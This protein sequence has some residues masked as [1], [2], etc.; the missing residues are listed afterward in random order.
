M[1][2]II[3]II[4]KHIWKNKYFNNDMSI[5]KHIILCTA[6]IWACTYSNSK[7]INCCIWLTVFFVF[8]ISISFPEGHT[9]FPKK[10]P[11]RNDQPVMKEHADSSKLFSY[12]SDIP[13][14]LNEITD[15]LIREFI[16]PWFERI[17][18]REDSKFKHAVKTTIL[19]IIKALHISVC[20]DDVATKVSLK[21]IS[22]IT[23]HITVFNTMDI[24]SSY[25][26]NKKASLKYAIT[27][28]KIL[29]IHQ[30]ITLKSDSLDKDIENHTKNI[31]EK[32]LF[33]VLGEEE[34]SSPFVSVLSKEI[35]SMAVFCPLLTKYC[36]PYSWNMSLISIC[37]KILEERSQ[38]QEVRKILTKQLHT[39]QLIDHENITNLKS[40]AMEFNINS[41]T[42]DEDFEIFLKRLSEL[43]SLSDLRSIKLTMMMESLKLSST[44]EKHPSKKINLLKKRIA[45]SLNLVNSKLKY[46]DAK[47]KNI[48][49]DK[50]EMDFLDDKEILLKLE[51]FISRVNLDAILSDNFCMLYFKRYLT[52]KKDT[53]SLLY[54]AFW[55][56]I[57]SLKNPLPS[58]VSVGATVTQI[59]L[60]NME[61]IK[62]IFFNDKQIPYMKVLDEKLVLE[63]LQ[64][65]QEET[66]K[67]DT[68]RDV[69]KIFLELQHKSIL[70]LNIQFLKFKKSGIFI[71]MISALEFSSTNVY[72]GYISNRPTKNSSDTVLGRHNLEKQP[73]EPMEV[74]LNPIISEELEKIANKE[75]SYDST[76]QK[77][78]IADIDVA[79]LM[80]NNSHISHY[81]ILDVKPPKMENHTKNE[82]FLEDDMKCGNPL[83][84]TQGSTLLQAIKCNEDAN[85]SDSDLSTLN[86]D[87]EQLTRELNLLKHLIL[88]AELTNSKKQL[89]LLRNSE[90]TLQREMR[91]KN[92][93]KQRL[94]VQQDEESIFGRTSVSIKS[95][96][97]EKDIIGAHETVYYIINVNFKNE[98]KVTSWDIPRRFNEFHLLNAYMKKRHRE[99][100]KK[101]HLNE[102]FPS[103][104]NISLK[105]HL[106]PKLLYE[107]RKS[108]LETYLR[109]LLSI[110]EICRDITFREFLSNTNPFDSDS[111]D[112][113]KTN[114]KKFSIPEVAMTGKGNFS[115]SLSSTSQSP[116]LS[117]HSGSSNSASVKSGFN[118][119]DNQTF[120]NAKTP[121]YEFEQRTIVKSM[122]D[123]FIAIFS[124]NG[125]KSIWLRGGGIIIL[126]QQLF[127][128]TIEKYL[129]DTIAR[130]TSKE[131][132][133]EMLQDL[134]VSLWGPSG[135]FEKRKARKEAEL[136]PAS[137][138]ERKKAH[139]D[140]LVL[141]QA[142]FVETFS[143][144]VGYRQ[145]QQGAITLHQTLQNPYLNASLLLSILDIIVQDIILQDDW[146][147][148]S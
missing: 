35:L 145:A 19:K 87:I 13:R 85:E 109:T 46:L 72:T 80:K 120:T 11:V 77:L 75:K 17:D 93:L 74:I 67:K 116:E 16:V 102:L 126:L 2:I 27:Y 84:I 20:R 25:Q 119:E 91:K 76:Y 110:S 60:E 81:D 51:S 114:Q 104:T 9:P 137:D 24:P 147:N 129:R 105:Y 21:L 28:N 142:L 8:T 61:N 31:I 42:S 144:L 12:H 23:D 59:S 118:N 53:G 41:D 39:S 52:M 69:E 36:D 112:F 103:K 78:G 30:G 92:L 65:I 89:T 83:G 113:K 138:A 7:I 79:F 98:E 56:K 133:A 44:D 63:L 143:K 64:L 54:L 95:Y 70:H 121:E 32:A 117:M 40:C 132:T 73:N 100:I 96:F 140:S 130:F 94:V 55:K 108:K 49:V 3:I 136:L 101:L 125:V 14:E 146:Q 62:N 47:D 68:V 33:S 88:K 58:S 124:L 128:S 107:D 134:K 57:E 71:K 26:E 5:F 127:G 48:S 45:L 97:A 37:K 4:I 135:Y 66:N 131:K 29:K 15:L 18:S 141:I 115:A 43:D 139:R 99:V 22:L 106:S 10:L 50:K 90:R 123:L 1:I 148:L 122:C 34:M 82:I 111:I 38:A 6:V 86:S